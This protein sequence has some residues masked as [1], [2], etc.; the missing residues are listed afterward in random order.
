MSLARACVISM[1]L[2]TLACSGGGSGPSEEAWPVAADL[3]VIQPEVAPR[4]ARNAPPIVPIEDLRVGGKGAPLAPARIAVDEGGR[5]FVLDEVD[6]TI[7]VLDDGGRLEAILAGEGEGPG[8]LSVAIAGM[9]VAGPHLLVADALLARL[10]A[11]DLGDL[12]FS[13]IPVAAGE[14]MIADALDLAGL[15]DGSVALMYSRLDVG[16]ASRSRVV[17]LA[18]DGALLGEYAELPERVTTVDL[19]G[20]RT[21]L[22]VARGQNQAAVSGAGEA[23]VTGSRRYEIL[24]V[25][26]D[27]APRWM[28]RVD[29]P[30]DPMPATEVDRAL[31][32]VA[33]MMRAMGESPDLDPS[34]IEGLPEMLP[35]LQAIKIDGHGRL[36]VFPYVHHPLGRALPDDSWPVDVYDADG[37]LLY[38]GSMP[39]RFTLPAARGE[40]WMAA[41]GDHVYGLASDADGNR[42]VVRHRLEIPEA[43]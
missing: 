25:S 5:I 17:R 32:A 31:D 8:E 13:T 42:V 35:A 21:L 27:G 37:A 10:T 15:N 23:Y 40:A 28:L 22:P 26:P 39:A 18:P 24:A 34:A 11:W 12:S 16:G 19:G 30:R 38:S 3:M 29:W 7:R 41:R 4:E 14:G 6:Q 1:A 36:W 2:A 33:G 20:R 9:T 43:R